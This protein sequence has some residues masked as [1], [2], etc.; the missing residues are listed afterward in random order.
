M[1]RHCSIYRKDS[2]Q[3]VQY[4]NF[5]CQQDEELISRNYEARMIGFGET[6]HAILEEESDPAT[7]YIQMM[8]DAPVVLARPSVPY[9]IDKTVIVSGGEDFCTI[10]GLHDPCEVVIDDPDPLVETVT[11]TVTGGAF[12]FAADQVGTYT[13]GI[14]KFPFMPLSLEIMAVDLE[15]ADNASY[16]SDFSYEFGS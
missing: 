9:Q 16:S 6:E 3:I 1:R 15:A 14:D 7:Q 12:E 2:G 5:T 10:S 13:I 4:S 11:V 8:G